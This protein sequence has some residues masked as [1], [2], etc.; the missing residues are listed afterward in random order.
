MSTPR[1]LWSS[2]SVKRIP[3]NANAPSPSPPSPRIPPASSPPPNNNN[4][5]FANVNNTVIISGGD[6]SQHTVSEQNNTTTMEIKVIKEGEGFTEYDLSLKLVSEDDL[7]KKKEVFFCIIYLLNFQR[8][9]LLFRYLSAVDSVL[10]KIKTQR[11]AT[12]EQLSKFH[13]RA[14]QESARYRSWCSDKTF[15]SWCVYSL[16]F[17][18]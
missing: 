10:N 3:P 6:H 1:S 17:F 16:L 12:Q 7:A 14:A 5:S 2:G 15:M 8:E 11:K 13:E 18:A 4:T 9:Q